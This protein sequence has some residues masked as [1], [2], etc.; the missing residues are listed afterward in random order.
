[1]RARGLTRRVRGAMNRT[2]ARF[3][4][5]LAAQVGAGELHAYAYEALSLRLGKGAHYTPDFLVI[6]KSGLITFYE[7]KGTTRNASGKQAPY[8]KEAGNVRIKVAAS[9]HPY[10]AFRI[11]YMVSNRWHFLD[12]DPAPIGK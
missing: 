2:E 3:A 11:A 8:I 7:V 5:Y 12:I 10:F 9:M 1:M 4:D 6:D